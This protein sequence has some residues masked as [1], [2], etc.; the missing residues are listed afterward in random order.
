MLDPPDGV[1]LHL[2]AVG[3]VAGPGHALAAGL[4]DRVEGDDHALLLTH[5]RRTL[6][7]PDV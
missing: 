6:T 4:A 5:V 7:A 3:I 2:H 1:R